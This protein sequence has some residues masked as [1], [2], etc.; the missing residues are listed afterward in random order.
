[1]MSDLP[2]RSQMVQISGRRSLS[3]SLDQ[4]GGRQG[5]S[6]DLLAHFRLRETEL[7]GRAFAD[8][9]SL[10]DAAGP[11]PLSGLRPHLPRPV[12]LQ[13]LSTQDPP[14]LACEVR[15]IPFAGT[16][17]PCLLLFENVQP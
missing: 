5:A 13:G 6:P 8:C 9:F 2:E 1:M 4:D 7:A 12:F 11:I 14:S 10:R 16:Q 17:G 3:L 15:L